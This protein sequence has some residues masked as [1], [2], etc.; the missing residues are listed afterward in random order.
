[1]TGER[2]AVAALERLG[3][4]EYESRCFVALTRIP[5]GTAKEI[6][7]LSE[8]PRSRVYDTVERLHRRGLVDVHQSEP[9]EY[10]AVPTDE[11]LDVLQRNYVS[12]IEAAATALE[13][14]E[15]TDLTE[16]RGVWSVTNTEHV[17]DRV[18]SLLD[19][20]EEHVHVVVAD[21]SVLDATF[22]DRLAAVADRVT[23]V[24]EVPSEALG[25]RVERAVPDARVTG[26]AGL[27]RT[28]R[29]VE[30]WPGRLV[31]VD[32]RAVLASGVE[33]SHLPGVREESAVWTHGRDHG[34]AAW[35]RKLLEERVDVTE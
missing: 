3:L 13:D 9:R 10:R 4:T 22:L 27:E 6:S 5:T 26:S 23:V 16:D 17:S 35:I 32:R 20:A 15:S 2:E 28:E 21:D 11:A 31:M 1:M 12:G 7:K 24:V 18:A 29:V 25:D 34:F 8:V 30:K 33:E 14:V 19:G